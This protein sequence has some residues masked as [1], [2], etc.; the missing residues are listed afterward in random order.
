M[1][2]SIKENKTNYLHNQAEDAQDTADKREIGEL[3][4]IASAIKFGQISEE[5]QQQFHACNT[6]EQWQ[7]WATHFHLILNREDPQE[8]WSASRGH[9]HQVQIRKR[10]IACHEIEEAKKNVHVALI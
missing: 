2:I 5:G 7:S 10:D 9:S 1:K 4:K 3:Y 6:S 8:T